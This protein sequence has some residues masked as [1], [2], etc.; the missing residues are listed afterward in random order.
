MQLNRSVTELAFCRLRLLGVSIVEFCDSEARRGISNGSIKNW[1]GILCCCLGGVRGIG[2]IGD[3]IEEVL[4]RLF[5]LTR[6]RTTCFAMSVQNYCSNR[7]AKDYELF[8]CIYTYAPIPH[9]CY[10]SIA[11]RK[12][13]ESLK[14]EWIQ[15]SFPNH[16]ICN[17]PSPL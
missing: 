4:N 11:T 15:H 12:I 6:S 17:I 13:E 16:R 14:A 10:A 9:R 2:Q 7:P 5:G 1:P 3:L 8:T